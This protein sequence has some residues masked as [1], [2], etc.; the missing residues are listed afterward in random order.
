MEEQKQPVIK[1]QI[2]GR[3]HVKSFGWTS[4]L[5]VRRDEGGPPVKELFHDGTL[6][7]VVTADDTQWQVPLAQVQA[8][9]ITDGDATYN[10]SAERAKLAAKRAAEKKAMQDRIAAEA[11]ERRAEQVAKEERWNDLHG[12]QGRVR[13]S[14]AVP[15]PKPQRRQVPVPVEVSVETPADKPQSRPARKKVTRR[16]RKKTPKK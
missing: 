10:D 14:R 12:E 16:T 5:S 7:H 1:A 6:L 11:E 3:V 15:I 13:P 2:I 9:Q 4:S 8:L